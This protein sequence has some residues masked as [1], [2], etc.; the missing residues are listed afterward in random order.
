MFKRIWIILCITVLQLNGMRAPCAPNFFS[1]FPTDIL[2]LI[3]HY[4]IFD[5]IETEEEFIERT[6]NGALNYSGEPAENGGDERSIISYCPKVNKYG[7]LRE[8]DQKEHLI[9]FNKKTYQELHRKP[10]ESKLYRHLVLSWDADMFATIHSDLEAVSNSNEVYIHKDIFTAAGVT[11]QQKQEFV[12]PKY[13]SLPSLTDYPL[14]IAFNKQKTHIII[15]GI[16][17]SQCKDT[18]YEKSENPIKDHIIV[19]LT[20]TAS[21]ASPKKKTLQHY[22]AQKMICKEIK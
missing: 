6:K 14:A 9:I 1:K 17:H 15:H 13:F 21:I 18:T 7:I 10:I 5:D 2:D 20:I 11:Q 3:A 12:V 22:F 8:I 16:D 19:H 4:L